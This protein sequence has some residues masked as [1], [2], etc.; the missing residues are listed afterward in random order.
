MCI[1]F[2]DGARDAFKWLADHYSLNVHILPK[3]IVKSKLPKTMVLGSGD[4]VGVAQKSWDRALMNGVV[5]YTRGP[6][7]PPCS[8]L[9]CQ[10]CE[11]S[12]TWLERD[13]SQLCWFPDLRLPASRTEKE[14]CCL[15]A[16]QSVVL[17]SSSP[18][19]L[20]HRHTNF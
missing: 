19:E 2:S 4:P 13:P 15:Q 14:I 20:R 18:N 12:A 3:Y 6:K 10:G 16:N 1:S 8:L 9:P 5:L 7:E 11:K 17:C